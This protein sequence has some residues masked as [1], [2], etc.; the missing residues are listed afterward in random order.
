M[1]K[2]YQN[3]WHGISFESISKLSL[4]ELPNTKFYEEFYAN[5]SKKFKSI[6]EMDPKWFALKINSANWLIK[7]LNICNSS[8][9]LS[10][11]VGLGIIENHI[12]K[13]IKVDLHLQEVSDSV[14]KYL[15]NNFENKNIHIGKYPDC[16]DKK[17]KF[18]TIIL[19]GV[20]Y[21]FDDK[22]LECLF[23][24]VHK[25]LK[26]NGNILFISWSFYQNS[27]LS[28]LKYMFK[29]LFV[30]FSLYKG[31][32]QLW[33]YLRTPENIISIAEK[34]GFDSSDFLIDSSV[35][36]WK[37]LFLRFKKLRKS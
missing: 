6:S 9:T 28:S 18:D 2:F 35:G 1:R 24:N 10:I 33:G 27:L 36:E 30:H 34:T 5:F 13:N 25:Q 16:I 12:K 4:N 8:L 3:Q 15:N 29:E 32:S 22:Q 26:E 17:L 20:E 23:I 14:R 7:Q 11:G 37:T 31:N 21:V 19:C